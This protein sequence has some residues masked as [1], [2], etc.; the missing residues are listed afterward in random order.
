MARVCIDPVCKCEID[1]EKAEH[2]TEHE[3]KKIKFC[4]IECKEEFERDPVEY[5]LKS[6]YW[7]PD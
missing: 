4:S 7:G 5:Y 2:E 6:K 1:E 3:G